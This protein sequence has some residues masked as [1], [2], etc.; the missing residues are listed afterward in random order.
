MLVSEN[1]DTAINFPKVPGGVAVEGAGFGGRAAA[2]I[3]WLRE[4]PDVVYWGDLDAD[5]LTILNGYRAAGVD[6]RFILMD[7][8]TYER[9]ARFGTNLNARNERIPLAVAVAALHAA[10]PAEPRGSRV[11]GGTATA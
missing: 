2:A 1:K 10:A 6:T 5:G 8:N 9:Y 11:L 7:V 4:C 3:T